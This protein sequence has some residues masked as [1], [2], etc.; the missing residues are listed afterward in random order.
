MTVAT[1][2]KVIFKNYK[3]I[4]IW[5]KVVDGIVEVAIVFDINFKSDEVTISLCSHPSDYM[6]QYH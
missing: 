6:N 1:K 4:D 3:L 5:D 2:L